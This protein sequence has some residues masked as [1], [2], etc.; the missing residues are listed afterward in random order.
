MKIIID[1]FEG[2]YAVCEVSKGEYVNIPRLLVADAEEGDIVL[3]EVLKD[4]N[5]TRRNDM[6]KRLMGLFDK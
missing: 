3:I 2:E 5:E 6:K 4:E 1:R